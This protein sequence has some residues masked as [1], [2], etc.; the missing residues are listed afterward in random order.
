MGGEYVISAAR[1]ENSTQ[2]G[3]RLEKEFYSPT[4]FWHIYL[5]YVVPTVPAPV[6][7]ANPTE[8]GAAN[9]GTDGAG[10]PG[11]KEH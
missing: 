7:S 2:N 6:A 3:L 9:K 5:Y 11:L 1:I 8:N 4:S 10:G